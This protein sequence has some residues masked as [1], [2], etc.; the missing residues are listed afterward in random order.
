MD[1]ARQL[2]VLVGGKGT[3]LGTLTQTAPKPLM[4]ISEGRVFLDYF[5]EAAVRQGFREVLLIAGY[6]GE[7]VADRYDHAR[8]GDAD[9]SVLI[10]PEPMGTAG[11]LHFARAHL[12]QSFMVANGD[13]LF[14]TNIRALDAQ[15]KADDSLEAV[16]AL[17]E[18]DDVGRYGSIEVDASGKITAF[19][20]KDPARLGQTGLINGGIYA[21]RRSAVDR[22]HALPASIETDLFPELVRHRAVAGVTSKGY[23]L[24]IGLPETLA[25]ARNDLPGR[26]R[27]AV[28]FDRD[29]VL[30]I[31]KNYLNRFEDWEWVQGAR[32]TIRAVNDAGLAAVVVTNQAGVG[33]GYYEECDVWKLHDQAQRDLFKMGAFI[34]AFYYSPHHSE[35]AVGR[36]QVADPLDRKPSPRMLLRAARHLNLDLG[37]SVLIGDQESDVEAARRAGVRGLLFKGTDLK[38]LWP[39]LGLEA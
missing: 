13:T 22:I 8:I 25:T 32:E 2:V 15:L 39:D 11:A 36:Y 30:N 16:I 17:R 1:Y 33:R 4:P 35:G 7:Q 18:V 27:G 24:D 37:R 23:F 21:L 29:G 28:F 3:R 20:E 38:S 26:R 9:I 10:E 19:R 14:D 5:L 6:L 31:D 34:D 12:A